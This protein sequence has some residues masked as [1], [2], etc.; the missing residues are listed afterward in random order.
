MDSN[1]LGLRTM[2]PELEAR[3]MMM[4]DALFVI[5][6]FVRHLKVHLHMSGQTLKHDAQ[7]CLGRLINLV[8][9]T[10]PICIPSVNGSIS[11]YRD[12]P[13]SACCP[14]SSAVHWQ[15]MSPL[16]RCADISLCRSLC[17]RRTASRYG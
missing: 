3:A 9:P 4:A 15:E 13:L 6:D 10:L 17:G 11:E 1:V 2:S 12:K 7:F 16:W 14:H 5:Q 8:L